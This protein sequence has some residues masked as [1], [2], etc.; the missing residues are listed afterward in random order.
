MAEN[1]DYSHAVCPSCKSSISVASI[2]PVGSTKC[3][4]CGQQLLCFADH[5]NI[6]LI[7]VVQPEQDVLAPPGPDDYPI[8]RLLDLII[9]EAFQLGIPRIELELVEDCV[10]VQYEV[11]GD[12]IERD[13]LR[14]DQYAALLTRIERLEKLN[15]MEL[16]NGRT[17][18][19]EYRSDGGVTL[20]PVSS[21]TLQ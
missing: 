5:S 18:E 4:R 8:P 11:D 19:I 17:V 15:V 3:S 6:F 1:S 13:S 10:L 20:R 16:R 12:L 2:I 7:P 9:D 14:P 21:S